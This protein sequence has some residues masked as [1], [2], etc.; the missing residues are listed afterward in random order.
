MHTMRSKTKPIFPTV[1]APAIERDSI[2][3]IPRVLD[4]VRAEALKAAD[5]LRNP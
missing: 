3:D 2:A 1:T 5:A 4:R